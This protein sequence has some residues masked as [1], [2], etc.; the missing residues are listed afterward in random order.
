MKSTV[1]FVVIYFGRE[2]LRMD[3]K[4][5]GVVGE[6][7]THLFDEIHELE[8]DR[9]DLKRQVEELKTQFQL[10]INSLRLEK[11]TECNALER[12][13]EELQQSLSGKTDQKS[14][15]GQNRP[16]IVQDHHYWKAS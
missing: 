8:N 7:L 2:K 10:N 12:R 14:V 5:S 16:I 6:Q 1:C 13:V 15:T 11:M 3:Q 9:N 4:E